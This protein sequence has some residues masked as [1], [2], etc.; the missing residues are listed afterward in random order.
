MEHRIKDLED[1][2][3][4]WKFYFWSAV[5]IASFASIF[6][7]IQINSAL[8]Q[9]KQLSTELRSKESEV[10]ELEKRIDSITSIAERAYHRAGDLEFAVN[11]TKK[12]LIQTKESAENAERASNGSSEASKLALQASNT[13]KAI[14]VTLEEKLRDVELMLIEMKSLLE[15][16][17]SGKQN[18]DQMKPKQFH[19]QI[20]GS[21]MDLT[22]LEGKTPYG[23]V[24]LTQSNY[25]GIVYVPEGYTAIVSGASSNG[26]F[27][28]SKGLN[29]RVIDKLSGSNN[30]WKVK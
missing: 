20:L 19:V 28:I 25:D 2:Q 4:K 26:Y 29:G 1:F 13:S 21:N 11:E 15:V 8:S 16:T 22:F 3:N 30:N 23:D 12:A 17:S 27:V 14:A 10:N 5:T 18:S 24:R 6:F 7:G 9:T